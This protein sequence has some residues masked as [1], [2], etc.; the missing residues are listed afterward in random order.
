MIFERTT[1]REFRQLG[2]NIFVVLLAVLLAMTLVRVLDRAAGGAIE[3]GDVMVFM[4]LSASTSINPLLAL[5]AFI[6][7]LLAVSRAFRD[8]EM[9]VW[10]TAGLNLLD[11]LRPLARFLWP[12]LLLSIAMAW[13]GA[14]WSARESERLQSLSQRR[15]ES[16]QAMSGRF[17]ES[18]GGKRVF[19]VGEVSA[20]GSR[21]SEVFVVQREVDKTTWLLARSGTLRTDAQ[22]NRFLDLEQGRRFDLH[23]SAP[24]RRFEWAR[25]LGFE[26]YGLLV[27]PASS[28][29]GNV[30]L[31]AASALELRAAQDA[32]ARGELL[33]RLGQS[34]SLMVLPLLAI[35]LACVSPRSGR[36]YHLLQALLV[37]LIYSSLS[38]VAESQVARGE[39]S[40]ATGLLA[41][42]GSA[43][44][45]AVVLLL[46]R[47]RGTYPG[48]L[49]R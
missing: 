24:D 45:V 17:R 35:G 38:T 49:A 34:L 16:L 43:L 3:A 47:L 33:R 30:P 1:A 8:Q 41:V 2:L 15:D 36:A 4:L 37:Y 5:T 39:W 48:A 10:F 12:L 14:P 23:W 44:L 31:R 22:G 19:F 40:F 27:R 32:G 6:A 26:H 25:E 11:W 13:V 7:V 9:T 46:A 20:E 42:H 29:G 28:A 21:V 18:A